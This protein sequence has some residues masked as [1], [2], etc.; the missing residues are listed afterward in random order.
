MAPLLKAL[1]VRNVDELQDK[2]SSFLKRSGQPAS[3]EAWGVR[4]EDLDQLASLGI[5]KG[6]ADNNPVQLTPA[7]VKDI[8]EEI[9][10]AGQA[11][12]IA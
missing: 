2:I 11:E 5:T 7:H 6:R 3:L 10:T 12:Q 8:L 1:G 4:R 9:Y